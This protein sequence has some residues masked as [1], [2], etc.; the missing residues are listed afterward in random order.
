LVQSLIW[1][2][3]GIRLLAELAISEATAK[4]GIDA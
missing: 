2:L 1:V 4:I 3:L